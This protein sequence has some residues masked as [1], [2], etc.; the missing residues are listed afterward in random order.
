MPATPARAAR[1]AEKNEQKREEGR[2]Q[3]EAK[4]TE[5]R[6]NCNMGDAGACTSLGEW[7]AMLR[8]D[9]RQAMDL[10]TPMCLERKYPQACLNMGNLLST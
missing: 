5:F 2:M 1:E 8:Q 6:V 9:F 3:N 7:F 4:Y 10:Y